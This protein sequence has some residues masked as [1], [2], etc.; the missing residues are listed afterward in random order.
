MVNHVIEKTL[1][2]P[3]DSVSQRRRVARG[4]PARMG[5]AND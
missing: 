1:P 2:T 4:E 5:M 3:G